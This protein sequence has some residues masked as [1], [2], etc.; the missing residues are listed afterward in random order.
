MP[1]KKRSAIKAFTRAPIVAS[2]AFCFAKIYSFLRFILGARFR[3]LSVRLACYA[4]IYAPLLCVS[5]YFYAPS[6]WCGKFRARFCAAAA[7]AALSADL[8]PLINGA[9]FAAGLIYFL[10]AAQSLWVPPRSSVF[11]CAPHLRQLIKFS[12]RAF[13]HQTHLRFDLSP[14]LYRFIGRY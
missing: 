12:F 11:G 3:F 13:F 6:L 10:G 9:L 4:Q 14:G 8:A 2:C 1:I 7:C 5:F